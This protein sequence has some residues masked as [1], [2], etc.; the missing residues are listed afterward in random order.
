MS[1]SLK[2]VDASHAFFATWK[3]WI[4]SR[5]PPGET[6]PKRLLVLVMLE[7]MGPVTMGTL[8][9]RLQIPKPNLTALI[10]ELENEAL[11]ARHAHPE[12]KRASVLKLT[13]EGKRFARRAS[14]VFD[15][16]V[17]KLFDVLDADEQRVLLKALTKIADQTRV[18]MTRSQSEK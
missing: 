6:N 3:Q 7:R 18:P 16:E 15:A 9:A 4:R 13:A 17:A 12:D 11:L 10:D 8:S 14:G 5:L 2:L 1:L